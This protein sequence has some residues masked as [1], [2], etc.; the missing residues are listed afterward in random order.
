MVQKNKL[1][2]VHLTRK[3][4]LEGLQMVYFY[5]RHPVLAVRDI[6]GLPVSSPHF[7][8]ALKATWFCDHSVLLLSRGM[9]KSTIN[10]VVSILKSILYP[11]R[12]QLVLGPQFRQGRMIFEDS[13]IEK[14]LSDTMGMQVHRKGFGNRSCRTPSKIINKGQNDVWRVHLKNGSQIVTGPIGKKGN[15]LL[16]LRANDIRLDEMRDF[17]K[18]QVT[19]VIHPFANVLSDPFSDNEKTHNVIGNTFM[20]CGTIRYT[21]D[22]YY[23]II[24]EY[25]AKMVDDQDLKTYGFCPRLQRGK[26]CVVEFNYE[27]SF[28]L[29]KGIRRPRQYTV[30]VVNKLL[31]ENKLKFYFR[32]N[33]EEIESGKFSDT[34]SIEDWLA[35][36]KNVPIKLGSKE[37]PYLL[38]QSISD[39][40]EF[41]DHDT[42]NADL[43]FPEYL[44]EMRGFIKSKDFSAPLEPL[45]SCRLP[46]VMGVD[47]ATES[48]KFGITII[49]PGTTQG[50]MFDNIVYAFAKSHM[51]YSDMLNKIL[52]CIEIFNVVLFH[53]DKRGGGT[54]LRDMLREPESNN[55]VPIV[56]KVNDEKAKN[57][58]NGRD[59]LRLVNAS[60][61]YNTVTVSKVKAMMQSKKL[62]M[63][64]MVSIHPNEELNTVYSDLLA[65]RGQFGKIKSRPVGGGWRKYYVPDHKSTDESLEKGYKDLFSSTMYAV[66]ALLSYCGKNEKI[67]KKK[68]FDKMPVPRMVSVGPIIGR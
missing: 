33:I 27:D 62:Y 10:A 23:E 13:G 1:K 47:V 50:N 16:G 63:P 28:S 51:S 5:R 67:E 8:I 24:D 42:P 44:N 9:M 46:T 61:E 26:Y 29:Q 22:Y 17:T 38:L 41:E 54:A 53:M 4:K 48:D 25:M 21:D 60:A 14:I 57:I 20:Y 56:D 30:S 12:T 3:E 11:S 49:R 31:E 64:R 19:K 43:L 18:F 15:S 36:N 6:L 2:E 52:T 65:L 37:F 58:P 68:V 7:R 45:L 34:V 55:F 39:S 32:I 59:M 35:E 66:D 40:I